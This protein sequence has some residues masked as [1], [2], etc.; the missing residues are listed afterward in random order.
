M[1]SNG[2]CA[3][4]LAQVCM[5]VSVRVCMMSLLSSLPLSVPCSHPPPIFNSI[6]GAACDYNNTDICIIGT[7]CTPTMADGSSAKCV[8]E[9]S[10]GTIFFCFVITHRY[11]SITSSPP[12]P[13]LLLFSHT[14]QGS[15]AFCSNNDMCGEGLM[16]CFLRSS[17]H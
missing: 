1:C 13:P 12:S 2:Q 14:R 9:Y 4:P 17:R 10:Q 3:T 11:S 15:G 8:E 6:K 5:S 16:V 7:V